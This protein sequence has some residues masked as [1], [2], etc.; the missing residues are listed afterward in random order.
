MV[1][2]YRAYRTGKAVIVVFFE[3][4]VTSSAEP[5]VKVVSG[6]VT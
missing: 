2:V 1:L 6:L 4:I 3:L 5:P